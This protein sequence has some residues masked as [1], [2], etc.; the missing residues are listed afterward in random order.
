MASRH[1]NTKSVRNETS[2]LSSTK[3]DATSNDTVVDEQTSVSEAHSIINTAGKNNSANVGMTSQDVAVDK[4][5]SQ[6][7][8]ELSSTSTVANSK[9]SIANEQAT[10]PESQSAKDK[11]DNKISA[12][13]DANAQDLA[14]KTQALQPAMGNLEFVRFDWI[15][16]GWAIAG[17]GVEKPAEVLVIRE[18]KLLAKTIANKPR[19]DIAKEHRLQEPNCGFE[20]DLRVLSRHVKLNEGD[21][22]LFA[23]PG[24]PA[25]LICKEP[26][27][28][29]DYFKYSAYI[30]FLDGINEG[31]WVFGWA[32]NPEYPDEPVEVHF[33]ID[34]KWLGSTVTRYDR[35]DVRNAGYIGSHAGF[36]DDILIR[37]FDTAGLGNGSQLWC[38]F[39]KQGH[40]KLGR[41]PIVLDVDMLSC[42]GR[43]YLRYSSHNPGST[44]LSTNQIID[45]LSE[46]SIEQGLSSGEKNEILKS[47]ILGSYLEECDRGLYQ[48]VLDG[49]QMLA[50]EGLID[51]PE[52]EVELL[53]C[54]SKMALEDWA[55]IS[56]DRINSAAL[57]RAMEIDMASIGYRSSN[58]LLAKLLERLQYETSLTLAIIPGFEVCKLLENLLNCLA[59]WGSRIIHNDDLT[60]NFIELNTTERLGNYH[61]SRLIQAARLYRQHHRDAKALRM[62]VDEVR[63]KTSSWYPYHETAV[64]IRGLLHRYPAV[65]NEHI[66]AA[67]GH[68]IRAEY[69]NPNQSLSDREAWGLLQDFFNQEIA[70]SADLARHG[71]LDLAIHCRQGMLEFLVD[72]IDRIN[73]SRQHDE[74]QELR[75]QRWAQVNDKKIVVWGSRGLYQCFYYRV[76]EKIDQARSLGYTID[77]MDLSEYGRQDWMRRLMGTSLIIACRIPATFN[78]IRVLSYA[79]SAGIPIIYDIDDLIFD[80]EAFPPPLSTYAGTIDK[81]FHRHLALDNPF[82]RTALQLADHCIASTPPLAEE[83]RRHVKPDVQVSV[84]PNLLSQEVYYLAKSDEYQDGELSEIEQKLKS[85]RIIIFYGSA[86]K[87]HKQCFYEV[88]LPALLKVLKKY[89]QVDL[90]LVG[91]F[92]NLPTGLLEAQRI[93]LLDATPDYLGYL[94]LLR[95]ADINIAVLE[96]SRATDCKSEIKW[97]E[98]ACFAIPSIVSPTASYQL[99]LQNENNALFAATTNEWFD[100]CS[101]LVEDAS[102][103]KQIGQNARG[104]AFEKFNPTVGEGILAN[105]IEKYK[106]STTKARRKRILFVNVFYYPQSIGGATRVMESQIRGLQ[107]YYSDNYD[108]FVLTTHADPDPGRPYGVEQYW[109]NNVLV[110]RLHVP[111]KEWAEPEDNNIK[112]FCDDFFSKYKID[113]I[114]LHSIQVLTS[115][116]ASSA[117]ISHIPFIITLHDAW[118]LSR[119]LF[120]VDEKGHLVDPKDPILGGETPTVEEIHQRFN[121]SMILRGVMKRAALVMAVSDKFAALYREAGVDNVITHE[122]AS[123]PFDPIPH[124]RESY[125]KLILGF[126]G[127]MSRH[128]GY[129]LVRQA[130]E[131]SELPGFKALIVDHSLQPG[132]SYHTIWGRTEVEFIPKVKQREIPK[133]YSE[134]DILLAPSIWPESYGLVTR[135]AIQAGVWVIASDRGAI[136]DCVVEGKNGNLVDVSNCDSLKNALIKLAHE[137]IPKISEELTSLKIK[138]CEDHIRELVGHYNSVL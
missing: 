81:D 48:E 14:E 93:V 73:Q 29:P 69:F 34:D 52:I 41:S 131:E 96:L 77:L 124:S 101:R 138:S 60:L 80:A 107:E 122:N 40:S 58:N 10:K 97:L 24:E 55:D 88:C 17:H 49:I 5:L 57:S 98:A 7:V 125:D 74:D 109:H 76:Q 102:L 127:G 63:G 126:I 91:Y 50:N 110:T 43:A 45:L 114:H 22:L 111:G 68:F 128:K 64:I 108:I 83:I 121:R 129:H 104:L 8:N 56:I 54:I 99:A 116:I 15:V 115:S 136:G 123:E 70:K 120:L 118:W 9:D 1:S 137:G 86:T 119:Y 94:Q 59:Q 53:I 85:S 89:P 75:Y 46:S 87:A 62:L 84:L 71:H 82:F 28:L 130:L 18:G 37:H 33:Y 12:H 90:H 95:K 78:E 38:S 2:D 133:L 26:I 20:I 79:R 36:L 65:R 72:Q 6:P 4:Q 32:V 31:G 23:I 112:E 134:M 35:E 3:S 132:E 16:V 25:T 92:E 47:I 27:T 117:L 100:Q 105:I 106:Y 67:I 19:S 51:K 30:G 13:V 135:E 61:D 113:L 21:S 44:A 39:D 11:A 66:S 42:V 103:R